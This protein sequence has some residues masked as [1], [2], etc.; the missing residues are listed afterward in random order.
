VIA[1]VSVLLVFGFAAAAAA[2][3]G[4]KP[5]QIAL[6]NPVQAFPEETSILGVRL[7]LL[8]GK[9]QDVTGLDLGLGNHVVGR[10]VG[11][12]YGLVGYVE[13]SFWGWQNNAFNYAS[14]FQGFQHGFYNG[15]KKAVGFELGFVNITE[16]AHG[17]QIG[18]FNM[19]QTLYGLQIGAINVVRQK[20]NLPILP[21]VN[22][23]F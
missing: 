6:F 17:L 3:G 7:N 19:T 13:G 15:A 21:I 20:E 12:Q 5:I 1:C 14:D 18:V 2:E 11:L 8:Y 10:A 9:N 4:T 23:S 22:W 16:D